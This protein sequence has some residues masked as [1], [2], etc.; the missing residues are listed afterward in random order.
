VA[1]LS[2]VSVLVT[3]AQNS[4]PVRIDRIA[5]L[6]GSWR[7]QAFGGDVEEIWNHPA[8][9]MMT[10]MFRLIDKGKVIFMEFEQIVEQENSLVFKVKHF[11]LAFVGWEEKEKAV[12]FKL[13]SAGEN[14]LRFDGLTVVNIVI[15]IR[16]SRSSS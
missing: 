15:Q 5:W 12:E 8:G 2:L 3:A 7:G 1:G 16:A 10:G 9:G 13:L 11:T 4:Q 14:E 6:A